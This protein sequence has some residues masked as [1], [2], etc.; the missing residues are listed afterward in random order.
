MNFNTKFLGIMFAVAATMAT[1]AGLASMETPQSYAA[2][3]P[4]T[5]E[6]LLSNFVICNGVVGDCNVNSDPRILD[7]K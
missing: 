7:E 1:S 5:G 2:E 3:R 4:L 6:N